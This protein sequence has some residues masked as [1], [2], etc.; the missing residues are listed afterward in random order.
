MCLLP[1]GQEN[2][3]GIWGRTEPEKDRNRGKREE[4]GHRERRQGLL[5]VETAEEATL[6]GTAEQW[7]KAEA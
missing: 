5:E 2:G 6:A 1:A 3:W 7:S 4:N